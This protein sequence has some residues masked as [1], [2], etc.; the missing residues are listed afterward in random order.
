[1]EALK[2]KGSDYQKL[3]E[4]RRA[5][6]KGKRKF[7]AFDGLPGLGIIENQR[8]EELLR[9]KI[10][11]YWTR[12][13]KQLIDERGVWQ[14]EKKEVG[15]TRYK[16]GKI[17]DII[18]RRMRLK[19][20]KKASEITYLS[21]DAYEET[22]ALKKTS[23]DLK[24]TAISTMI[25]DSP[26]IKYT[27]TLTNAEFGDLAYSPESELSLLKQDSKLTISQSMALSV[28]KETSDLIL[29]EKP[30]KFPEEG[31][32]DSGSDDDQL[33]PERDETMKSTDIIASMRK[34]KEK[35]ASKTFKC[36]RITVRGAIWGE[37]EMSE[38]YFIF[39]PLAG[40]RPDEEL[41]ELG[42]MKDN[43]ITSTKKKGWNYQK[44]RQI[45]HRRYNFMRCAFEFFTSENKSYYFNVFSHAKLKEVLAEFK[46]RSKDVQ[47]YS[48]ENFADTDIQK[49]WLDGKMTNFEYL[50]HLNMFAGR[51]FNDLTQ[52]P[53]F[54]WIIADYTSEE[55]NIHTKDEKE[56]RRIF[57]DLSLPLGAQ[58]QEKRREVRRKILDLMEVS[59]ED[60]DAMEKEKVEQMFKKALA[61]ND[62]FMFGSHYSTGGHIIDYLVRLEPFTSN[63]I[64]LQGGKLD[65]PNRIFSSIP[66]AWATY[67]L[68]HNTQNFKELIPEFFYCPDFLKNRY[69]LFVFPHSNSELT[70]FS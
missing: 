31:N 69:D 59:E 18:H 58:T 48:K 42:T 29:E 3:A 1:M 52:Y 37:I 26:T 30:G 12:K 49:R 35:K 4:L 56:Q 7:T 15:L 22:K 34:K 62:L 43:M 61:E 16:F 66:K 70:K 10:T 60:A 51:S 36:E 50:I 47:I 6:I 5:A 68:A 9:L 17:E 67:F 21:K 28:G 40:E 2:N 23:N 63:Q 13:K 14:I 25:L 20:D 64:K 24:A 65:D 19:V 55:I 46:H 53:V 39:R 32:E 45:F 27:T 41:Y 57:R 8:K 33:S 11:N 44:I 54:P 38:N